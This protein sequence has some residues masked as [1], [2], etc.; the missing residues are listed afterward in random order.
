MTK[1]HGGV[2]FIDEYRRAP[3]GSDEQAFEGVGG[4]C[5]V[6]GVVVL[7]PR[8]PE[9]TEGHKRCVRERTSGRFRLV[10]ATTRPASDIPA[11]LRSRCIEIY[12]NPLNDE[13]LGTIVDRSVK[14]LGVRAQ[15]GVRDVIVGYAN[16]GRDAVNIVQM[17]AGIAAIVVGCIHQKVRRGVGCQVGRYSLKPSRR[18]DITAGSV[19]C[20]NSLAVCGS[21]VGVVAQLEAL[22]PSDV[23][24]EDVGR[25]R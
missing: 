1:A 6:S 2:L 21:G 23:H 25:C 18:A 7:Q 4:P 3:S 17:A 12:F 16:N 9:H 11:A 15:E 24:V 14:K 10:G 5:G 13:Q 22:W 19:G 8:G 20:V